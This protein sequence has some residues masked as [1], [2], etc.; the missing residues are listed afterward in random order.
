M[1]KLPHCS[2]RPDRGMALVSALIIT[3]IVGIVAMAIG[4]N[5][6]SSQQNASIE[7]DALSGFALAQSGMNAAERLFRNTLI[8]DKSKIFSSAENSI[9]TAFDKDA[10]WWRD[11]QNWT[12]SARQVSGLSTGTPQ[13]RIEEREFIPLSADMEERNGRT[14]FRVSSR[15][16][17]KGVATAML[18]S[19][20]GVLVTK[21]GGN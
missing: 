20:L 2:F 19:Y 8:N 10:D 5:A 1:N 6:L 11:A 14:F 13:F 15:G 7:F 9:S 12:D 16:E 18:Q 21:T 17:G 4:R 3:L